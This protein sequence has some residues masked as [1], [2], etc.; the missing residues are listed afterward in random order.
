MDIKSMQ[1]EMTADTPEIVQCIIR[2]LVS[3]AERFKG[4][5]EEVK[6]EIKSGNA[7][8]K[9]DRVFRVRHTVL[10]IYQKSQW[11]FW[12]AKSKGPNIRSTKPHEATRDK[13]SN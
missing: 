1:S 3:K 2:R 8:C 11:E 13:N 9:D 6:Q 7:M 5:V 4:L 12:E 10:A